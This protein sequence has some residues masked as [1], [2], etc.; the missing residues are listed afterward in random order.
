LALACPC[1]TALISRGGR[2]YTPLMAIDGSLSL[3]NS[4]S[5]RCMGEEQSESAHSV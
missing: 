4:I 2:G 5:S 3:D 1:E